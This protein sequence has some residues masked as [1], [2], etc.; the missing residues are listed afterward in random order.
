M[1][2]ARFSDLGGLATETPGQIPCPWKETTLEGKW[3]QGQRA[4]RR[5]MGPG[6]H[7]GSDI[8]Q[9]PLPVDRMTDTCKNINLPQIWF[10]GGNKQMQLKNVRLVIRCN[11]NYESVTRIGI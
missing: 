4:P 9:K 5:N 8:I 11:S 6:S 10:A 3:D 2:A 1:R 7:T